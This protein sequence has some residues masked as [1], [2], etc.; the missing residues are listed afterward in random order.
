MGETVWGVATWQD[1][2]PNNVWFSVYVEG[3]TNAYRFSDDPAK[4]AAS[5]GQQSRFVKSARRS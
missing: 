1:V 3:L 4:Y 2:D 5:K